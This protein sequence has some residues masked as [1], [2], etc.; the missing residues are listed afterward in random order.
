[1]SDRDDQVQRAAGERDPL[2]ADH[3]CTNQRNKTREREQGYFIQLRGRVS[4]LAGLLLFQSCSSFI[5]SSF[6]MLL[7][8]H[9]VIVCFL[10]M[11]VG[12][13]GNAGNQAA[14]LVIRGLATGEIT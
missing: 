10:T 2:C 4:L 3:D 14:V 7:Q 5:L 1:M 13:G 6:E 11:L 12:A 8:K 9:S